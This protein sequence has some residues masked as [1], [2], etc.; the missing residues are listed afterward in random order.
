[1]AIR[2]LYGVEILICLVNMALHSIGAKVLYDFSKRKKQPQQ[3]LLIMNLSLSELLM[4]TL[5]LVNVSSDYN[6]RQNQNSTEMTGCFNS[7]MDIDMHPLREHLSII[8]LTGCLPLYHLCMFYIT[9][10]RYFHFYYHLRYA[11]TFTKVR[12]KIVCTV[13]WVVCG[14]SCLIFTILSYAMKNKFDFRDISYFY[15]FPVLES[16]FI[17]CAIWSYVSIYRIVHRHSRTLS[18]ATL[19]SV[20]PCPPSRSVS[21]STD[22][23]SSRDLSL[24]RAQKQKNNQTIMKLYI[25]T[26]LIVTFL[27]FMVAPNAGY[28]VYVII[29]KKCQTYEFKTAK[30]ILYGL[31]FTSDAVI[32]IFLQSEVRNDLKARVMTF[33]TNIRDHFQSGNESSGP[34]SSNEL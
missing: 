10:D 8:Q 14:C 32:Y 28:L 3:T 7:T 27:L 1:M 5:E 25:P 31:S 16:T 11:A 21:T 12:V 6:R 34:T 22:M 24:P 26:L 19:G 29:M 2:K 4:M 20:E 15:V 33:F 30:W 23:E 17:V 18:T 9:L 13:T